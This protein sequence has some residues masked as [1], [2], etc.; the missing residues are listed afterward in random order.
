MWKI[1][2]DVYFVRICNDLTG[3]VEQRVFCVHRQLS[4]NLLQG[5]MEKH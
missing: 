5:Q 2:H 1:R 4:Y 3:F